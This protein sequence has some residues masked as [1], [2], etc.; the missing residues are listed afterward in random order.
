MKKILLTIALVLS[1]FT[2][3]NDFVN[4]KEKAVE[5]NQ[6]IELEIFYMYS[7]NEGMFFLEPKAETENVIFVGHSDWKEWKGKK[8]VHH[9]EKFIGIF[10]STG[11]E[12]YGIKSKK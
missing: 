9:G 2:T 3:G 11:W 6:N 8:K 7:T 12:L 1:L 10:D 5:E 4:A